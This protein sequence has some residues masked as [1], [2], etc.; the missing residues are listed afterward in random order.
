MDV[1]V[2]AA[3][4]VAAPVIVTALVI[5]IAPVI[6]FDT[7]DDR[8]STAHPTPRLAPWFSGGTRAGLNSVAASSSR[9]RASRERTDPGRMPMRPASVAPSS[10]S[11]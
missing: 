6:V 1:L 7:V 9:A 10:S 5:L 11:T 4:A 3:V 8:P 2:I